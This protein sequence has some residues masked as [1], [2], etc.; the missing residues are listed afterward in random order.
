MLG[1]GGV[2]GANL[3]RGEQHLDLSLGEVLGVVGEPGLA[4]AVLEGVAAVPV[5]VSVVL[6]VVALVLA[7]VSA[8]PEVDLGLAAPGWDV[9]RPSSH[10]ASRQSPEK[11]EVRGHLVGWDLHACR[12]LD[13]AQR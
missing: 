9:R 10:C 7:L 5:L 11:E 3:D 1:C 13:W 2:N 6:G 4:S 8:V 12:A